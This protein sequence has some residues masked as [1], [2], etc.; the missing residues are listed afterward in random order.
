MVANVQQIQEGV[1]RF[2]ENEL[3]NKATGVRK[4]G[5]Y[6]IMPIISNKTKDYIDIAKKYTPELFTEDGHI[7]IDE[8][9]N[10][11]KK[12]IQRSGQFEFM[13]IIFNESD[14]DKLYSYIKGV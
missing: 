9:Y 6:F 2:V 10:H 3:A 7:K 12:A 1:V 13:G 5:I 8:V 14:V 4:F 11:G